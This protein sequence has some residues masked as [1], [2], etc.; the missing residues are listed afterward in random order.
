MGANYNSP[1]K[2]YGKRL[3]VEGEGMT[4][5][6]RDQEL[7]KLQKIGNSWQVL[8]KRF[9]VEKQM[10]NTHQKQFDAMG[11]GVQAATSLVNANTTWNNYQTA[12]ADNRISRSQKNVAIKSIAIEVERHNVE[13]EKK[14]AS[15]EK[16]KMDLEQALTANSQQR[17]SIEADRELALIVG[18]PVEV[19]LPT[20]ISNLSGL[21]KPVEDIQFD[22]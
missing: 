4:D 2:P 15:L 22:G 5:V 7:A 13:L 14:K 19:T 18:N 20:F 21:L 8:G 9:E 3:A 10:H 6:E 17:L 16:S 11:A 1:V 12:V